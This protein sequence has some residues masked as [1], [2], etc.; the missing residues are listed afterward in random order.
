MAIQN[1]M[2]RL[3]ELYKVSKDIKKCGKDNRETNTIE[4]GC[5]HLNPKMRKETLAIKAT[6]PEDDEAEDFQDKQRDILAD[7][8]MDIMAKVTDEN[9][10]ILGFDPKRGRPEWMVIKRLPVAPPPVRPSVEMMSNMRAEDD[11]TTQYFS[12]IKTNNRLREQRGAP[13][14]SIKE[15]VELLQFYCATLINNDLS[16][17]PPAK[18][19]TGGKPIKSIRQR[20]KGK[21]GRLRGNL[22]GKRVD[23]SAR[24]VITP[25]PNLELDQLGVPKSI[26]M[27][28][29][30][31]EVVTP[32]NRDKLIQIVHN[33]PNS[34]PGAKY[35]HGEGGRLIDLN[36]ARPN[37]TFIENGYI[38]ERHLQNDDYVLFNRQPSLHKMSIMGHRVKVLPYSTFRL[39]LSVTGPY[40]A[41]FDG[42]EMNMFVPQSL[43]TK[44]EA[45]EIIHVPKQIVSPQSNSPVMGI[46]QD[47]LAGVMIFTYRDTFMRLDEVMQLLM[48]VPG[49]DGKIPAPAIF[50]PQPLWTGKQILSMILPDINL[51]RAR[52]D[53]KAEHD[54]Y[55]HPEDSQVVIKNG[56]LLSGVVCKKTVGSG[57]GGLI[58]VTMLERGH[59]AARIFITYIQ[60]LVNNWL[61]NFGHTVGVA[62]TIAQTSIIQ[63]IS[64][65]LDAAKQKVKDK[66]RLA[67]NELLNR[68]PGK[69]MLETFEAKVNKVMNEARDSAGKLAFESLSGEN[70]IK[71]MVSAGSKGNLNNISQIM[72]CVGQ[73]N[74]EGKRIPFGFYRRTLPHFCRDDYG[75]ESKG[76]VE[77]S[78]LR[79]L[80]PQ[81]FYFHAMGG[82]EGLIDTAVKTSET[83]YIQRRLVKALE[84]IQVKYDG[85]VRN[86]NGSILQFLYGE[87][88]MAGEKLEGQK[89]K[90]INLNDKQIVKECK[91][92]KDDP[93]IEEAMIRENVDDLKSNVQQW[94]EIDKEFQQIKTDRERLRNEVFP[95]DKSVDVFMPINIPRLLEQAKQMF[96]ITQH[97]QSDLEPFDVTEGIRSLVTKEIDLLR[98]DS[99]LAI[100]A[101]QNA[102]IMIETMIRYQLCSKKVILRERLSKSS[103][104][105]VL[106]EIK[107]KF[108]RARSHPGEMVG[109][110]A[111]Q[112]IG[113]PATQMTLNTFHSAGISAKNVTLGV[114]RLKEI[115]NV[116][117]TIK[118]PTL[119]IFIKAE[120]AKDEKVMRQ[121]QTQI[122]HLTLGQLLK[123]SEIYYDPDPENTI[124][125]QDQDL[126]DLYMIAPEAPELDSNNRKIPD[127]PWVLR[128]VLDNES[129]AGQR[130]SIEDIATKVRSKFDKTVRV[131]NSDVNDDTQVIR[132]RFKGMDDTDGDQQLS[133]LKDFQQEIS[134]NLSLQGFPE[135]K[136]VYTKKVTDKFYDE[137]NGAFVETKRE[138]WV[139][140]TDGVALEKVLACENVDHVR[141]SSNNIN[142]ILEVLGIEA[143]RQSVIKEIREVLGFYS[144]YVNYRHISTLCDVMTQKGYLSA[145]TRHGINRGEGA[146]PFRKCS[147]EET[148]E[149]LLEAAAFS[150]T[151]RLKGISEAIIFGQLAKMGT[152][153]FDL[154]LDEDMLQHA[155]LRV[156]DD[157]EDTMHGITTVDDED[158]NPMSTPMPESTPDN[159]MHGGE[160]PGTGNYSTWDQ[161]NITMT[162]V[163]GQ[164]ALT[165]SP[166]NYI[167]SPAYQGATPTYDFKTPIYVP[168]NSDGTPA[169]MP[170]DTSS[171]V[172]SPSAQPGGASSVNYSPS[173]GISPGTRSSPAYG[174]TPSYSP[175]SHIHS[176]PQ[177]SPSTSN[178]YG[179]STVRAGTTASPR[180]SAGGN[181][182]YQADAAGYAASP[183]YNPTSPGY[184]PATEGYQP[185]Q[186]DEDEEDE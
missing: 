138:H 149:I 70:K 177:Y 144:I 1:P 150:E 61:V 115:I 181:S 49:F 31:P 90:L 127:S 23:F 76:F 109:S 136:K 18:N 47:T 44:A 93:E 59:E 64:E 118:T 55:F 57:A 114:P 119:S 54:K 13:Y 100:Q 74:V 68:Q 94:A 15:N 87:D 107:K 65:T 155:I 83:G 41:D 98:S 34:W 7:Q 51:E 25:D 137:K 123:S 182:T 151:D 20:L 5:G 52:K 145:I 91:F 172:Y 81:E 168:N 12:I 105:W 143:V 71:L 153:C 48:W 166:M 77:N 165:Q 112:S 113:E 99:E 133:L 185:I 160:T 163:H 164:A 158:E 173:A 78:Y 102:R 186:E 88:G 135:I 124:I 50:K 17:C 67:Q 3:N 24:T 162:P 72:A 10:K 35:I 46:V 103:F 134:C 29:T 110:I 33:G 178:Q 36:Y 147:F 82:R 14:H 89:L 38:V 86:C 154:K 122:E 125:T 60:K 11:L 63:E 174:Q 139:I 132:F 161:E 156:Q 39:N 85:S 117:T 101:N 9:C 45:K 26:A 169:G 84:D 16:G 130:L 79:G 37:E 183:V 30:I 4:D 69:N 21:E 146:G 56:E 92:E 58:H 97:S 171:P 28:L 27:T 120:H 66:I 159:L 80:T 2:K 19:K 167:N 96:D 170:G 141:T 129:M 73:Q 176:S 108:Q 75:P 180:Y 184:A 142:E 126:V 179:A 175:E 140:E 32:Q 62:D 104:K 22:M 106:G 131:M 6:Y 116:A 40:N 157:N 152:G 43:E 53:I 42:D 8:A 148:V 95:P 111:A 128:M 121:I